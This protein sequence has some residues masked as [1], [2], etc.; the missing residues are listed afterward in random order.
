MRSIST[1][2]IKP[3]NFADCIDSIFSNNYEKIAEYNNLED[4]DRSKITVDMLLEWLNQQ[5]NSYADYIGFFSCFFEK[6]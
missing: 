5:D 1:A 4:A 6:N 2:Y 3:S